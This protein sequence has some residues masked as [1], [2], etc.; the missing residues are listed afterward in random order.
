MSVE[1]A[2][3]RLSLSTNAVTANKDVEINSSDLNTKVVQPY[4]EYKIGACG[5]ENTWSG[6]DGSF[7]LW[8][9][10]AN[11]AVAKIKYYSPHG[12]SYNQFS[13]DCPTKGWTAS[14]TGAYLGN[15]QALGAITVTVSTI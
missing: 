13:I 12:T 9:K 6:C 1:T 2:F 11:V 14:Q 15:D 5:R 7:E 10:S 8:D 4:K 3:A